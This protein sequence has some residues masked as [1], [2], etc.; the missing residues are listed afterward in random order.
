[1]NPIVIAMRRLVITLML[2]VALAGGGVVGLAKMGVDLP[3]PLNTPKVNAYADSIGARAGRIKDYVVGKY[4]A[5][6]H[7]REG[8]SHHEQQKIVATSPKV[9][10]VIITQPFV[11][12]I[13]AQRHIEV[14]ALE[15][16]YLE[17]ILVNE[18]QVVKKPDVM[19]RI[20]PILYEAK[21]EAEKAEAEVRATEVDIR[22]QLGREAGG[23]HE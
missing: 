14:R 6:F 10:D 2:V 9:M 21:L 5:Y 3:P 23:L 7:K 17:K 20:L 12:Q 22:Q 19:F 8:E 16:G 1:M 11:C 18:G 15:G 13:R 4:Q